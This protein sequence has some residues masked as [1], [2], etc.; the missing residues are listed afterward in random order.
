M[1]RAGRQPTVLARNDV[2]ERL[3]ASLAVSNGHLFIR[4]DDRLLCIGRD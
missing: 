2:G 4:N 3:M 1:L